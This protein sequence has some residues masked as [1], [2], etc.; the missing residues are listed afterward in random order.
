M[1][2]LQ[3]GANYYVVRYERSIPFLLMLPNALLNTYS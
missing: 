1:N 2:N 3:I